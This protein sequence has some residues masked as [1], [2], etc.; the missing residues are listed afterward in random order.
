MT[1]G[2]SATWGSDAVAGV[3]NL[4]LNKNFTGVKGS[5]NYGNTSSDTHHSYK[6]EL[7]FGTDFDGERG[8]VILSGNY[9]MSPDTVILRPAEIV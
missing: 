5:V 7:S 6:G 3:V 2:A 9:T 1:G 4:V 8:H